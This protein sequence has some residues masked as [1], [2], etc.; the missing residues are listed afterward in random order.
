M[1]KTVFISDLH[2]EDSRPDVTRA[3]LFFLQQYKGDCQALFI[4]GD[5][6]EVWLGDDNSSPLIQQVILSLRE[7]SDSGAALY[8]MRGNRDFLLGNAFCDAT[9][10]QLLSEP[11]VIDLYGQPTLLLHGDSLCTDDTEYQ[12]YRKKIRDPAA[13]GKLLAMSLKERSTLARDL[14]KKSRTAN[15]NKAEN[16]MDV[17][18]SAVE[19]IMAEYDVKQLIH[20]H[21][22]RPARHILKVNGA[23]A[24]RFVLGDWNRKGWALR[25]SEK[26]IE[27]YNFLLN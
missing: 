4:L 11:T 23:T 25:A 16:I 8:I 15:S 2:L 18:A 21:T 3:L 19:Q 27:L 17:N 20:G 24:E 6:F 10:A 12:I 1:T 26:K 14:R 5:L 22:H 9:G 7:M 13:I